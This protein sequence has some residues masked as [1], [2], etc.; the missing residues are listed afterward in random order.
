M[1][2]EPIDFSRLDPT[3]D[4]VQ[5]DQAVRRITS[6]GAPELAR[7]RLRRSVW[8]QLTAWHKPVL[9]IGVAVLLVM[10]GATRFTGI[11][12]DSAA[13]VDDLSVALGVPVAMTDW[14]ATDTIPTTAQVLFPG[15]E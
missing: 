10:I 3:R 11:A 9:A 13:A 12:D 14:V 15:E 4:D 8:W 7:R 5:F 2:D 1:T 6:A